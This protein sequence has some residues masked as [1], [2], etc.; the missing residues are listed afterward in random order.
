ML[1]NSLI[2]QKKMIE[3]RTYVMY[4]CLKDQT[5][6]SLYSYQISTLLFTARLKIKKS[7]SPTQQPKS[8]NSEI[9]LP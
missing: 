6:V 2:M 3:K 4:V 8:H 7:H 9:I 1:S 5:P